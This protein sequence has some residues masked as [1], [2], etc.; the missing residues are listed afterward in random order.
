MLKR[1]KIVTSLLLVLALFGLLQLTSGGLF[2]NSLKNDKENFTVLQ[3]IRQQ[4]SA[5]NATWVEL[6]QTRNTLNRAGIRW[7]MD[8]SN[9]GSGATVAELMQGATNTLKL[10]E[11]NWEQ[12]EALPRDP[13]QSEAA[14]LE[15]KR[16]YDIY[17]GALAELIQLLGAGKINEFF[18]QPTQ[19]Y[20]DAFEKQYMAYMQQ[21]DRLYDI[22][23]E[24]NN[25]SYNQAMWVLVSVLIAVLVV[26]IAV[27]VGIKL[28]LI[29]PMNRLIESIRHIASGDLVKRI[30]VEGSNE[31]GQLAENLRHMQS[32]LM[33]TVGDVRNGANAIYSGASEIAMGNNDLSS[34]TEQQ[35]ASLEETAASMEQLT[36]TVKQNAENA[37]QAS[38][39]ALSASETAQKGG[40]VVDNVVQTMRDIASSSQKIADI[41]SVI[42][43]IAFQTNIL[44]LNAAVEA[45]RAGEQGRGFAV[46]AGEVR[47]LAQ[48]SAQAAR[49]IKSLIEDSV[50]RVD[51]GSTLVESAGET[52]DEI[53]NA[54]TRVT[55]IM[56]EIASASDE[57]SRGIDQ[58]GLAVAE[59]DRV[60]QQNASLVEE[61]AA[62]AAALEE[63]ASRLTQAVAVFRI[64]QQQQRAR[65]VAAVKTP[66]AV[67]SPKAAVA[68]G[69]D[70]WETF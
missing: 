13:R 18:D 52:M 57:Q 14:F 24:D 61:S 6:L 65:E 33:R 43:G 44:A 29:A 41:I 66:A 35:A 27:W 42:D 47:N 58:V 62:A 21:N 68:D 8:Q 15:I 36:A 25:S 51:V 10:T 70:N 31:M 60:T 38:H 11:K 39:L 22:A 45:A 40:K 19:S 32:E 49:E 46:V 28:S 1:I 50:S 2:F 12:Y 9:I 63:Q 23:V 17:H 3:T 54:V 4:Q 53:V 5:L 37:R 20:Q 30:D 67:S 26:I 59:M 69:S 48:R 64:Q 56:G 55:D 7:M 16:T 34:R